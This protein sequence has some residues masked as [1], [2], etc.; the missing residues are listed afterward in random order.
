MQCGCR[1]S[2]D[3]DIGEDRLVSVDCFVDYY[4]FCWNGVELLTHPVSQSFSCSFRGLDPGVTP[5]GMDC[6]GKQ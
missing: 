6:R 3:A 2:L 5:S 4:L 1:R